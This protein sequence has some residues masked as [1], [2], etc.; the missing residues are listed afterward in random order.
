MLLTVR[1]PNMAMIELVYGQCL[2]D[3]RRMLRD[4][5]YCELFG[6]GDDFTPPRQ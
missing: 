4:H 1:L 5:E 2:V 6:G 3:A